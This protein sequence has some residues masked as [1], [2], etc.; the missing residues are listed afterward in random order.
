VPDDYPMNASV[1]GIDD[2]GRKFIR[3]KGVR[4]FTNIPTK[5]IKQTLHLKYR[6][7][8]LNYMKF[9][10]YNAIEV[11]KTTEIPYDYKGI[12]A[13]PI[14]FLDKYCPDQF[15]IL[16][17]ANG[18]ARRNVDNKTLKVVGYIPH[19]EDK[20][21]VGVIKGKRSYVRVLIRKKQ[22]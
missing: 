18:N 14:T 10:N 12:M 8:D 4:W 22:K 13:V 2:S 16:M 20:G 11:K 3:V 9:E 1:C 21:G 19:P 7:K 15:E 17:L 6:Y 5:N